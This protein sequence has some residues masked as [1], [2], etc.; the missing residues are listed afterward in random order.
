MLSGSLNKRKGV[1]LKS[2]SK[3]KE[4]LM[5]TIWSYSQEIKSFP[6]KNLSERRGEAI[7]QKGTELMCFSCKETEHIKADC[8][9]LNKKIIQEEKESHVSN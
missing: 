1:A 8:P 5:I 9:L 7:N 6:N 3:S 2:T 4:E